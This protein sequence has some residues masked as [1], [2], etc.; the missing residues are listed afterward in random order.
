[1]I[2]IKYL[3]SEKFDLTLK[4]GSLV[5]RYAPVPVQDWG[6]GTSGTGYPV[7]LGDQWHWV[8]VSLGTQCHWYPVNWHWCIPTFIAHSHPYPHHQGLSLSY[9]LVIW[10]GVWQN[11]VSILSDG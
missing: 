6:L 5:F 11:V 8:L 7:G 1:M 9:M 3:E 4:S 2:V 10:V